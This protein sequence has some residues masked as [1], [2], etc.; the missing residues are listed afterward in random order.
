MD[1]KEELKLTY[2]FITHNLAVAYYIADR[3]AIM[4]AGK[5]VEYGD[6]DEVFK[7]PMHPYTQLL[8]KSIPTIGRK[9]L[10]PPTGEVPSL[11]N[12]PP[13]CR[14][15]PRCPYAMDICRE[16]EPEML[17]VDKRKVACWLYK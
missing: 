14:F 9:A 8:M 13:G 16:R 3:V 11:I 7:K 6:V 4:Y 17:S 12:P 1:L 5:V 15:N 2:L 10:E